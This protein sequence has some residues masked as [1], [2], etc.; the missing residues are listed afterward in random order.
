MNY[1][2]KKAQPSSNL[3]DCPLKIVLFVQISLR[4]VICTLFLKNIRYLRSTGHSPGTRRYVV[5]CHCLEITFHFIIHAMSCF[6]KEIRD[7]SASPSQITTVP[8]SVP[9]SQRSVQLYSEAHLSHQ[10]GFL[11][12]R[13]LLNLSFSR[14]YIG[15]AMDLPRSHSL[16]TVTGSL[17]RLT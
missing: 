14:C 6:H 7:T 12:H 9:D 13:S 16:Y 1:D 11:A 5:Y 8:Y 15:Y 17:R 2:N 4:N 3:A 10:A